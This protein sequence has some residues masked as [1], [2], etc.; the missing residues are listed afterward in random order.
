MCFG[1]VDPYE[2]F[3]QPEKSPHEGKEIVVLP[4]IRFR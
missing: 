3:K 4:K 1:I 2:N